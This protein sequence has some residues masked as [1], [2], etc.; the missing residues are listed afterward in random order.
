MRNILLILSLSILSAFSAVLIAQAEA[1]GH[2]AD[3]PSYVLLSFTRIGNNHLFSIYDMKAERSFWLAENEAHPDIRVVAFDRNARKL[4]LLHEGRE[5]ELFQQAASVAPTATPE[6]DAE[7][8]REERRAE[9][10][11]RRD[12]MRALR[13]RWEIAAS[14]SPQLQQLESDIRSSGRDLWRNIRE[15]RDTDPED[16][17]RQEQ[18]RTEITRQREAMNALVGQATEAMRQHPGFV[19]EDI[20]MSQYLGRIIASPRRGGWDRPRGEARE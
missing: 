13:E 3:G 15:L 16:H 12:Q 10:S 1:E 17:A 14:E 11:E 19:P 5:I 4:T 7:L 18:L 8:T 2:D 6:Q 9:R 20:E